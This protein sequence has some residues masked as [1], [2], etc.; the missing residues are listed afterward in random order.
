[1]DRS[2]LNVTGTTAAGPPKPADDEQL[3]NTDAA[4]QLRAEAECIAPRLVK[5]PQEEW[6]R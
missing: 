6:P 3:A 1:V 2:L 4:W 5:T